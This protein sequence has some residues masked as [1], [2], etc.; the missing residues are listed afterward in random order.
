MT[1]NGTDQKDQRPRSIRIVHSIMHAKPRLQLK[2]DLDS[3]RVRSAGPPGRSP[4]FRSIF[5]DSGIVRLIRWAIRLS[6]LVHRAAQGVRWLARSGIL[7]PIMIAVHPFNPLGICN[8][9]WVFPIRKSFGKLWKSGS[10]A[11]QFTDCRDRSRN[12]VEKLD[13]FAD[14]HSMLSRRFR[15]Q[16]GMKSTVHQE[17]DLDS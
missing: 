17:G 11:P 3:L 5:I 4:P 15:W 16:S 9:L 6:A 14:S 1:S 10:A 13:Q 2:S 12:Y 7:D 8:S